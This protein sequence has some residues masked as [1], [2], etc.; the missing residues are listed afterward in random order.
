VLVA[1]HDRELIQRVGRRAITLDHGT[2]VEV[3]G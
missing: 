1:T 3:T 2:I